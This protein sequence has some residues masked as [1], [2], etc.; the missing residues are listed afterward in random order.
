[1]GH[2]RSYDS[3]G[4]ILNAIFTLAVLAAVLGGV[5]YAAARMSMSKGTT[6]AARAITSMGVLAGI[7]AAV[8]VVLVIGLSTVFPSFQGSERQSKKRRRS[9]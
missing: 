5:A 6:R 9:L 2:Q 3:G 4:G 8:L 1:M 7:V